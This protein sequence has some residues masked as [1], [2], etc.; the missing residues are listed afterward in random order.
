MNKILLASLWVVSSLLTYWLGLTQSKNSSESLAEVPPQ[1]PLAKPSPQFKS[2]NPVKSTVVSSDEPTPDLEIPTTEEEVAEN[3]IS[4]EEDDLMTRVASSNPVIRLRAFTELL[5]NPTPDNLQAA[6]EAYAKLP[7]GPS[8]FSELRMLAFSWGQVDPQ[9][10]LEW[11]D[12]LSGFEDR[13]GA[14]AVMDSW[15]RYDSVSAR[16]WAEENFEGEEN[17]YLIGVVSGMSE[18]DLVGASELMASMPRSRSRGRA[19]SILLEKTWQQGEDAALQF[20]D[21]LPEGSLQNYMF[22]EIGKKIAKDDMQRAVQWVE[23]MDESEVKVQVSEDIAE[24]WARE[25]PVEA[26]E[27]VS[28]MPE[29]ESRSESMEEVVTQWARKDPTATAEWLNQ[30]PSGELMDEPI[31]RFVREVVRKEPE[32]ALTWAEAIVDEERKQRV[33]TEVKRVAERVAEREQAEANGASPDGGPP[34]NG[35]GR[36]GPPGAR[37]L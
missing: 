7:G 33:V 4:F 18:N 12:G 6:R 2:S 19:A 22:G 3:P 8:R 21:N 20:A 31:E 15:A 32:T 26:A 17:P 13:I 11:V 1:P 5:Q 29:G 36:R 23:R 28:Q 9:A 35:P 14:G 34:G 24:R 30:F 16:A 25:S 10:A 27:W 37:P